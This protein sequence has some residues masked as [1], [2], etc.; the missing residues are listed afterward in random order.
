MVLGFV[1]SPLHHLQFWSIFALEKTPRRVP[2]L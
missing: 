1:H 2:Y